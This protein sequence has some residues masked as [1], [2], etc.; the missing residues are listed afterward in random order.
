MAE[1]KVPIALEI[2]ARSSSNIQKQ[3]DAISKKMKFDFG[4]MAKF[5]T[6][7]QISDIQKIIKGSVIIGK[8]LDGGLK[9]MISDFK[10]SIENIKEGQERLEDISEEMS[11]IEDKGSPEFKRLEEER[12]KEIKSL[13]ALR[14]SFDKLTKENKNNLK[15]LQKQSKLSKKEFDRQKSQIASL[16]SFDARDEMSGFF[17]NL[18]SMISGDVAGGA[19]GIGSLIARAGVAGKAKK[20]QH[21]LEDESTT[22]EQ[23]GSLLSSMGKLSGAAAAAAGAI[24]SIG[25][26]V[27]LIGKASAA[28]TGMNKELLSGLGIARDLSAGK[29]TF[30]KTV[31]DMRTAV[32]DFGSEWVYMGISAEDALASVN[33]FTKS[34]TGSIVA[35]G[36]A[37]KEMT[38]SYDL[39]SGLKVFVEQS[40]M[41]ANALGMSMTE[42]AELQGEMVSNIG[43]N[44]NGALN[45]MEDVVSH[46]AQANLPLSKFTEIFRSA[47]PNMD[48]FKNRITEVTGMIKLMS[49]TMDP[50]RVKDFMNTLQKGFDQRGF[51]DRLKMALV[52]GEKQITST[53]TKDVTYQAQGIAEGL[54]EY[55]RGEFDNAFKSGKLKEFAAKATLSADVSPAMID[56][57]NRLERM[58]RASKGGVTDK[59]SAMKDMSM[60][61]RLKTLEDYSTKLTPG[62]DLMGLG[63]HV[64]DMLGVTKDEAEM[65]I[66]LR[67]NLDSHMINLSSQGNTGSRSINDGLMKIYQG[68]GHSFSSFADFQEFM[69]AE[70]KR[71]PKLLR[72]NVMAAATL[73][74]DQAKKEA[75]REAKNEA[76]LDE[77]THDLVRLTVSQGDILENLIGALLKK[78][79]SFIYDKLSGVFDI[80]NRWLGSS[81]EKTAV[82]KF[83]E[84][85]AYREGSG[86]LKG[87]QIKEFLSK[88]SAIAQDVNMDKMEFSSKYGLKDLDLSTLNKYLVEAGI[89]DS[90]GKVPVDLTHETKWEDTPQANGTV[91]RT[92]K[93]TREKPVSEILSQLGSDSLAKLAVVQAQYQASTISPDAL[94]GIGPMGL[95]YDKKFKGQAEAER[96]AAAERTAMGDFETRGGTAGTFAVPGG[97][98]ASPSGASLSS[99]PS[100]TDQLDDLEKRIQVA[101]ASGDLD[102]A[103][104][105]KDQYETLAGGAT[106]G[107]VAAGA[108]GGA[109]GGTSAQAAQAA[110]EN[111]SSMSEDSNMVLNKMWRLFNGKGLHIKIEDSFLK[112]DYENTVR[113][114]VE[115]GVQQPLMDAV[116]LIAQ[117][118][119]NDKFREVLADRAVEISESELTMLDI[120][121]VGTKQKVEGEEDSYFSFLNKDDTD[122][123]GKLDALLGI[124]QPPGAATGGYVSKT[125]NAII[126]AG[127]FIGTP[128]RL[129]GMESR[130]ARAVT[131]NN[132]VI[133]AET[134]ASPESI[135][136]AIYKMANRV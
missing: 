55:L 83:A 105:L 23:M 24:A 90:T 7:A 112:S 27:M 16:A 54:P 132:L 46:A 53:L 67:Q 45:I 51:R 73:Q 84:K 101:E 95:T 22:E 85:E 81:E 33:A 65:L 44:A 96:R 98:A 97:G 100:L 128:N 99:G 4:R 111:T 25:A 26:L 69:K 17:S 87:A 18:K 9:K 86:A 115:T 126:H 42:I 28:M 135:A 136:E 11:A 129:A 40:K 20:I 2:D 37:F 93:K 60:L 133:N 41:Y 64:A 127:E 39:K 102:T 56:N 123:S 5:D 57:I 110:I 52:V 118:W 75:D 34:T 130:G 124:E 10:A 107:A 119:E 92:L 50:R 134:D 21:G 19:K 15:L 68:Q 12:E 89:V 14:K 13:A 31:D 114:A 125:G 117:M 61:G 116:L 88:S 131:I 35:T 48:L 66:A 49:K 63:E 79:F 74:M 29:A 78:L 58:Q 103:G 80:L 3:L 36:T 71:N 62:M 109:A 113:R 43:I 1:I 104:T 120:L 47:V 82:L 121:N 106:G 91:V 32:V 59:A 94:A 8:K 70:S 76:S 122:Y 77:M 30:D 6:K 38:S 108:A 72:E